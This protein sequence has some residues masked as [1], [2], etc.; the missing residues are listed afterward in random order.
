MP[1]SSVQI[2]NFA[3]SKIGADGTIESLTENSAEANVCNLWFEHARKQTL[4][5]FNWSFAKN[6]ET[7][8][9][10]GDDPSDDWTYRYVY[11]ATCLKARFIFNPLGKK[12]DPVP[13]EIE[14][15]DSGTK[16]I[17]TDGVDAILIFTKDVSTPSLYTEWFIETFSTI[18]G[19]HI[20][21]ALT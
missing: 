11:P 7:L 17:L 2:A 15:S 8:A 4:A 1:I 5:A 18:L 21:Y 19:A 14:N 3:L 10:H 13:F 9:T 12:A 16:S 6:R 20:S